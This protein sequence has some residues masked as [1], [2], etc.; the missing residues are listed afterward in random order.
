MVNLELE[1]KL[2]KEYAQLAKECGMSPIYLKE[3]LILKQQGFNNQEIASRTGIS[4]NTI[5]NYFEKLN[6][7]DKDKVLR[8]ILL[9]AVIAGG[10]ALLDSL[11]GT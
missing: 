8:L 1:P 6:V 2:I 7:M 10:I 4:P 5:S 3:I 11:I 9:V